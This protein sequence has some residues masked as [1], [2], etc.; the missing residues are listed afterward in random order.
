MYLGVRRPRSVFGVKETSGAFPGV[1]EGHMPSKHKTIFR[2]LQLPQRLVRGILVKA[3]K[4][5]QVSVN[6]ISC[7]FYI[8]ILFF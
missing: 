3:F 5:V 7:K 2:L 8:N 6:Y 4:S 1:D